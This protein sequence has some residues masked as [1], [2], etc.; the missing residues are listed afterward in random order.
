[1]CPDI[2]FNSHG[3]WINEYRLNMWGNNGVAYQNRYQLLRYRNSEITFSVGAPPGADILDGLILS[4]VP[5]P[6][7]CH[8]TVRRINS[9]ISLYING[10]RLASLVDP[11]PLPASGKVGLGVSWDL[12]ATFDNFVVRK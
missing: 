4:P 3:H 7:K 12:R 5:I 8:V 1:M 9:T 10:R 6:A 2:S 11:D